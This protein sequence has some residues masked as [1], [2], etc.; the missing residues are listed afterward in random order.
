MLSGEL[1][2]TKA[3]TEAKKMAN[4]R[5]E[6]LIALLSYIKPAETKKRKA[7]EGGSAHVL[8]KRPSQHPAPSYHQYWGN[9][10]SDSLPGTSFQNAAHA[11]QPK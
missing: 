4:K 9:K 8:D 1:F 11:P 5:N 6:T 2:S 3:L 10:Q 7:V